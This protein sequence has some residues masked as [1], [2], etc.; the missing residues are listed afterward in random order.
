MNKKALN[1]VTILIIVLA[2][3]FT[4]FFVSNLFIVQPN[5]TDVVGVFTWADFYQIIA[6]VGGVA[7]FFVSQAWGGLKSILGRAIFFISLGL[8]FQNIGQTIFSFYAIYWP[9]T[10]FYP[11]LAD[12][13]FF[14]SVLSYIYGV[15]LICKMCGVHRGFINS[16]K[17]KLVVFLVPIVILGGS[18]FVF[19]KD[20]LY[21]PTSPIKV[22]LDFGYPL[23][24]ALYIA[25]TVLA[26]IV[27]KNTL[28]GMM[29]STILILFIALL[30]Q[31]AADF[32]FLY[33]STSDSWVLSGSYGDFLYLISYTFM[34]LTLIKFG[35]KNQE[36]MKKI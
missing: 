35:Y 3:V 14:G 31:Y 13:G 27:S 26:Y 34:S 21:D 9:N 25:L 11:S 16:N 17:I 8:F 29:R 24:Q 1:I 36:F 2:I 5:T 18:Y 7:G 32:N 33:Q 30:L 23:G 22:F 4:Y 20:Y 15:Y 19:L 6:L 28:G 10:T 12:I